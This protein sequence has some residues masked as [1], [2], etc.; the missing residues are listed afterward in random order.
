MFGGKSISMKTLRR[1]MIIYLGYNYIWNEDVVEEGENKK[2][3]KAEK[4]HKD[5]VLFW[6]KYISNLD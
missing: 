2:G 5:R 3:L 4:V 1:R 6:L